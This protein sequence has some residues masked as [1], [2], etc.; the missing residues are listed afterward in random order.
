MRL[1]A[2][3]PYLYDTAPGQRYRLE[4]WAP[5]LNTQ[6]IKI[7]FEPFE[8][9]NLNRVLYKTGKFNR[10]L[11]YFLSAVARRMKLLKRIREFDAVIIYRGALPI[12][13]PIIERA[14]GQLLFRILRAPGQR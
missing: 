7:T 9:Q 6:G 13:P 8:D 10:K 5:Y 2:L 4:Q 12:G 14:I 3:V 11:F 1:L